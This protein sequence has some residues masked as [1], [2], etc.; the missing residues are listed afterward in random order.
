MATNSVENIDC[1]IAK[2]LGVVGEWWTLLILRNC[3]HGMRTFDEFQLNLGVST[4]VLSARLKTLVDAGVLERSQSKQDGRSY[5]YSL[6]ELGFEFYP[7]MVGL[8]QWGEKLSPGGRGQRLELIEKSSGKAIAGVAVLSQD[9]TH[10][11]PWDVRPVAGPGAD[12]KLH[13]LLEAK[14]RRGAHRHIPPAE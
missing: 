9:G 14:L 3:F 12:A 1:S 6:T 5:E 7:I 10:L 2:A 13:E 8:A 4:S 11:R